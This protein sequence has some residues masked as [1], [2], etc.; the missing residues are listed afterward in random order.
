MGLKSLIINNK[1]RSDPN[2]ISCTSV[3]ALLWIFNCIFICRAQSYSTQ[4][5][6]YLPQGF[7]LNGLSGYGYQKSTKSSI[8]NSLISNP[9]ATADFERISFGFSYQYDSKIDEAWLFNIGHSRT[10][11]YLPQSFTF[12]MPVNDFRLGIGMNQLYNSELDYGKIWAAAIANNEQGYI[13]ILVHPQKQVIIFKNSISASYRFANPASPL[14]NLSIGIQYNSNYL[15]YK[16]DPR[17][18]AEY[19]DILS[20]SGKVNKNLFADNFTVGMRYKFKTT[21]N[22]FIGAGAYYESAIDYNSVD[23]SSNTK[24][25]GHIPDIFNVGIMFEPTPKL[26]FSSDLAYSLWHNIEV[27]YKNQIEL[28]INCSYRTTEDFTVSFGIFHTNREYDNSEFNYDLNRENAIFII[29]GI[30][31]NYHGIT[32]DLALADNH[33]LADQWRKQFITKIGLGVEL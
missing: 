2:K 3:I 8:A 21:N 7:V 29:G 18:P 6:F 32:L 16:Y 22:S 4:T 31:Y 15:T 5:L 30:V 28:A 33:L 20:G 27:T 25:V 17:Y 1:I 11:L 9:A 13:D 23:K 19:I 12:I 14:Y 24:Y 26:T 10:K